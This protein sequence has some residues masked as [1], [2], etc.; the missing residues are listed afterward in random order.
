MNTLVGKDGKSEACGL[1][2]DFSSNVSVNSMP[3]VARDMVRD[4]C[5]SFDSEENL[6]K[7]LAARYDTS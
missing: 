7:A 6:E 5:V 3:E 2:S 4:G 1:N